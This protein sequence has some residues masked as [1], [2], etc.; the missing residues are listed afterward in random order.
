M[1][2]QQIGLSSISSAIGA[3]FGGIIAFLIARYQIKRQDKKELLR[4]KESEEKSKSL[5]TGSTYKCKDLI[6]QI[7]I[8]VDNNF[9]D[10]EDVRKYDAYNKQIIDVKMDI[11]QLLVSE[12]QFLSS[13]DIGSITLITII[14]DDFLD[15][16]YNFLHSEFS[17][18]KILN[19]KICERYEELNVYLNKF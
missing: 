2:W 9:K 5:F 3:L 8:L 10:Y 4:Q 6:T 11:K 7:M 16:T 1:D 12:K 19:D 17:K 14:L 15:E 13:N 18:R